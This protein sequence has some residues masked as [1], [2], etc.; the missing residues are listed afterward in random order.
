MGVVG[1]L[2]RRYEIYS[3]SSFCISERDWGRS[4]E[5]RTLFVCVADTAEVLTRELIYPEHCCKTCVVAVFPMCRPC[6]F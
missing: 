5:R 1:G 3:S 6:A 4:S 2:G